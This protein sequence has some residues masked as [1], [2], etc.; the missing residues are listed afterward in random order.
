MSIEF[1]LYFHILQVK[2]KHEKLFLRLNSAKINQ[3]WRNIL[4]QIKCEKFKEEILVIKKQMWFSISL[5]ECF[6]VVIE[7]CEK[8]S[9]KNDAIV[10]NSGR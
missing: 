1:I 8:E 10:R 3:Q 5:N 7:I 2:L 9:P 6:T 4:R